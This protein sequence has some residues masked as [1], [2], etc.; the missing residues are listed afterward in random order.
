MASASQKLSSMVSV[1]FSIEDVV[2]CLALDTDSDTWQFII[3][4]LNVS[5]EDSL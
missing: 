3:N 1:L 4:S 5:E 2:E